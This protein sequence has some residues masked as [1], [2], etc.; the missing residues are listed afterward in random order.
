MALGSVVLALLPFGGRTLG[1]ASA[2]ILLAAALYTATA[3]LIDESLYPWLSSLLA[4]AGLSLA[5]SR[6]G[7]VAWYWYAALSQTT[8]LAAMALSRIQGSQSRQ[9]TALGYQTSAWMLAIF[10]L[11]LQLYGP[12]L[13]IGA[14]PHFV[15]ARADLYGSALCALL[16]LAFFVWLRIAPLARALVAYLFVLA[17]L[18]IARLL[19]NG[20]AWHDTPQIGLPLALASLAFL[21]TE[22]RRRRSAIIAGL[23]SLMISCIYAIA[24]EAFGFT[25]LTLVLLA[26][27][28]GLGAIQ[29][30]SEE[31]PT[32]RQAMLWTTAGAAVL[33]VL[34]WETR[35]L[36]LLHAHM[37]LE[38]N[39][40]YGLVPL[41]ALAIA[42]GSYWRRRNERL[43]DGLAPYQIAGTIAVMGVA[44][45]LYDS[46]AGQPYSPLALLG[47][48]MIAAGI[49][50]ARFRSL[51]ATGS[52]ALLVVMAF[53][54]Y[55]LF[56]GAEG[57]STL[58][59]HPLASPGA[60]TASI[61]ETILIAIFFVS[62]LLF[63]AIG[64]NMRMR[65]YI[66]LSEIAAVAGFLYADHLIWH[67]E[68]T[69]YALALLAVS[70]L[71]AVIA[72]AW[73]RVPTGLWYKPLQDASLLVSVLS[74]PIALWPTLSDLSRPFDPLSLS[75][76]L[77]C[78][79]LW[80]CSAVATRDILYTHLSA[81]AISGAYLYGLWGNIHSTGV[82]G[83]DLAIGALAW[84]GAAILLES[85]TKVRKEV[86]SALHQEATALIFIALGFALFGD[87]RNQ[88]E[89]H[90]LLVA[91][92]VFFLNLW[93]TRAI[94]WQH[95]GV[96]ALLWAYFILLSQ[97]TNGVTYGNSDL[98]CAPVGTY[99]LLLGFLDRRRVRAGQPQSTYQFYYVMGLLLVMGPTLI[100]IHEGHVQAFRAPLLATECVLA[101]FYGLAARLK[102]FI[103]GGTAFLIALIAVQA[104]G[105][106]STFA[107]AV[108]ATIL[109]L[110][111][112]GSALFIERR[113]DRFTRWTQSVREKIKEWE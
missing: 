27:V 49:Y 53:V 62:S 69:A 89:L 10:S 64:T 47:L 98:Y 70:A 90:T 52:A 38:Q 3:F 23:A 111:V 34:L 21:F 113:R 94:G 67:P 85:V 25:L 2:T 16:S 5:I 100:A 50:G 41:I 59:P 46:C 103:V 107:W 19:P 101:I 18:V 17:S 57:I 66:V 109:G 77:G 56:L 105:N 24:G 110:V 81:S 48:G 26:I 96:G 73:L 35:L 75:C 99:L 45:Q 84:A 15:I 44:I 82:V 54:A 36:P 12:I 74:I 55:L 20:V 61:R 58:L 95:A 14:V 51:I 65:F 22:S 80:G 43:E 40:G 86:T 108:Y 92:A 28:M 39:Y 68:M 102:A 9:Q 78:G 106:V 4:L 33:G 1:D 31:G 76:L 79:I 13:F 91:S 6:H 104:E 7:A 112:I 72:Y 30:A 32:E 37:G 42:H 97:H 60:A 11:V 93:Q 63:A 8:A 87:G 29:P 83:F 71:F 88:S